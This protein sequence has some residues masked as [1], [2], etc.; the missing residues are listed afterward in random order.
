MGGEVVPQG[1]VSVHTHWQRQPHILL[2]ALLSV[3]ISN[4]FL[5]WTCILFPPQIP[6]SIHVHIAPCLPQK[7][8]SKKD[9]T[10]QSFIFLEVH[11]FSTSTTTSARPSLGNSE[12]SYIS[13]TF[14]LATKFTAHDIPWLE[15]IAHFVTSIPLS[16]HF[17]KE[18]GMWLVSALPIS[19]YSGY[20]P[21]FLNP[22]ANTVWVWVSI[23]V[24]AWI[25]C[26][27]EWYV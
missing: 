23:W 8:E 17:Q 20:E 2:M 6:R 25:S 18:L 1:L 21:T 26:S 16:E 14:S 24:P 4:V 22:I 15:K 27:L 7:R 10:G 12:A 3:K 19:H 11:L 13:H 5:D 9:V